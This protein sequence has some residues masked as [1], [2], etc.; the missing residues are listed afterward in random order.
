[1]KLIVSHYWWCPI[2]WVDAYHNM[3]SQP[4]AY[5]LP[6]DPLTRPTTTP[7]PFSVLLLPFHTG[8]RDRYSRLTSIHH[9]WMHVLQQIPRTKK[10]S[11]NTEILQNV[12]A[13][14]MA[15]PWS[16][17]RLFKLTVAKDLCTPE[18]A[19]V[20]TYNRKYIDTVAGKPSTSPL[21]SVI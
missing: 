8:N 17:K 1:M 20:Q 12:N 4:I 13:I 15:L 14:S 6:K 11:H 21:A 7:S 19:V 18:P 5:R 3:S 2:G 9:H 16:M 10:T